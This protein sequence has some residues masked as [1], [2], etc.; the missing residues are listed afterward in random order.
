MIKFALVSGAL[1]SALSVM[2]G[3]FGAHA[4]NDILTANARTDTFETAVRYQ[5]F[6]SLAILVAALIM[7]E[8]PSAMFDWAVYLFIAGIMFTVAG[9]LIFPYLF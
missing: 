4:L 2:I 3:A 8:N 9:I 1:F 6:H 5:M 7:K